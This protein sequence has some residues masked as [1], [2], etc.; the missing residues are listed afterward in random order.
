MFTDSHDIY[1]QK[2]RKKNSFSNYNYKDFREIFKFLESLYKSDQIDEEQFN[3]LVAAAA[4]RFVENEIGM[5]IGIK[6]E[7]KIHKALESIFED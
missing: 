4:S 2:R 7:E 6:L 3:L 5:R 1:Y